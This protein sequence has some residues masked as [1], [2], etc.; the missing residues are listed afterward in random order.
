M[1]VRGVGE[2]VAPH[3]SEY[4]IHKT[5]SACALCGTR[6]V[7]PQHFVAIVDVLKGCIARL[8]VQIPIQKSVTLESS[9]HK[10]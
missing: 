2:G 9:L 6:L 5:F 7:C 8:A 4:K 3:F 10:G 1:L